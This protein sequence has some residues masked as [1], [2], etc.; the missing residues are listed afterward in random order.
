MTDNTLA[1]C[2]PELLAELKAMV[3]HFSRLLPTPECVRV[4]NSAHKLILRAEGKT[5]Q[6]KKGNGR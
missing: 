6:T 1:E 2:A 4:L 5:Q 3:R